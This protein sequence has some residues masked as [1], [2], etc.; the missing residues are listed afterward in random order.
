MA[1]RMFDWENT[2]SKIYEKVVKK[3][4]TEFFEI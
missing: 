3:F 4:L 1:N 2:E